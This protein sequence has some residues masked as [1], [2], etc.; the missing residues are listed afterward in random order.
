MLLTCFYGHLEVSQRKIGF[1]LLNSFK[2]N[3]LGWCFIGDYNEILTNDEKV[4]GRGKSEGQMMLF[5]NILDKGSLFD[6]RW[7]GDKFTWSNKD[8]DASFTKERLDRVLANQILMN[9]YI[10]YQVDTLTAICSDHR[11]ILLT[12]MLTNNSKVL[13]LVVSSMKLLGVMRR[14]AVA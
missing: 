9:C 12:C 14:V 8:E 13:L 10:N 7:R 5:R 6:L 2:T 11:P 3:E 4:G 1:D